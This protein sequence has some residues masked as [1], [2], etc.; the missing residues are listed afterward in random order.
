MRDT[1][2]NPKSKLPSRKVNNSCKGNKGTVGNTAGT[3]VGSPAKCAA[4]KGFR[5]QKARAD[6]AGGPVPRAPP[7][8]SPKPTQPV[9]AD[10]A[11]PAETWP[12]RRAL[13]PLPEGEITQE[14]GEA[15]CKKLCAVYSE[16][17]DGGKGCFKGA[18]AL[19]T[20][21][22]DGLEQ[23]KKSGVRPPAKCSFGI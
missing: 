15:H 12:A 22:P 6:A 10:R 9:A 4:G 23:I 1:K 17:F 14:V 20:L 2:Q 13:P 8:S 11:A 19:M 3:P 18:E 7:S 16:V 5:A 21:K